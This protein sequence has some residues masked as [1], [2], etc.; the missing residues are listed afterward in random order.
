MNYTINYE[1]N[2][3]NNVYKIPFG[4]IPDALFAS[5]YET[6]D[7]DDLDDMIEMDRRRTLAD[8][9]PDTPFLTDADPARSDNHSTGVINERTNGHRGFAQDPYRPEE[10]YGFAGP[11]DAD[12]R[13]I[14]LDPDMSK[15]RD[16][17]ISRVRFQRWGAELPM[18]KPEG[19]RAEARVVSDE[20]THRVNAKFRLKIYDR[21][22]EG[23]IYSNAGPHAHA[24]LVKK[25]CTD[26]PYGDRIEDLVAVNAARKA[27]KPYVDARARAFLDKCMSQQLGVATYSNLKKASAPATPASK[28]NTAVRE[29]FTEGYATDTR[30][31][32]VAQCA[33]DIVRARALK[34]STAASSDREFFESNP[35]LARKHAQTTYNIS[36]AVSYQQPTNDWY[37]SISWSPATQKMPETF[38]PGAYSQ[39][40]QILD[41]VMHNAQIFYKSLKPG[42]DTAQIRRK[43][44]TTISAPETADRSVG[45]RKVNTTQSR[46]GSNPLVVAD[47]KTKDSKN[48]KTYS[49]LVMRAPKSF[50]QNTSVSADFSSS[51]MTPIFTTSVAQPGGATA[52][53]GVMTGKF[54][55]TKMYHKR[56]TT[57]S[58]SPKI[59][60]SDHGSLSQGLF[61]EETLE[62][63]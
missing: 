24:S 26:S 23:M 14:N 45:S 1:R 55:N 50:G 34:H 21:Q 10:F 32:S 12:P 11:E 60:Y 6:G 52:K 13:G 18:K 16:E 28:L 8:F 20:L 29:N 38:Q 63:I 57:S 53:P 4:G 51:E 31:K 5:K 17:S 61:G 19:P 47:Q 40:E 30:Y 54:R 36:A 22:L 7:D 49:G 9:G 44:I 35:N 62:G 3:D 15:I 33:S 56:R 27:G 2:I 39:H 42:E 25:V 59:D 58:G 46:G 43:V 48:T 41:N 37:E